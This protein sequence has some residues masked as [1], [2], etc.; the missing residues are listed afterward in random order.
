MV[1]N[2]IMI[3]NYWEN[4]ERESDI[5]SGNSMLDLIIFSCNKEGKD[6]LSISIPERFKYLSIFMD[7]ILETEY[8]NFEHINNKSN[9]FSSK[10]EDK[11]YYDISYGNLVKFIEI[12][13]SLLNCPKAINIIYKSGDVYYTDRLIKIKK[14][15]KDINWTNVLLE[16]N[17]RKNIP[18]FIYN[19][20]IN[21]TIGSCEKIEENN[22]KFYPDSFSIISQNFYINGV[23]DSLCDYDIVLC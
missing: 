4:F 2:N 19:K 6:Y 23:I 15:F 21:F 22:F 13:E 10:S 3:I 12:H 17:K 11:F 18:V 7:P 9:I 1:I 20:I 5:E 8:V 16:H 14:I